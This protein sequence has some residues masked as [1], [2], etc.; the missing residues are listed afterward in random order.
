[1]D[2]SESGGRVVLL[3]DVLL[4]IAGP[5]RRGDLR[6]DLGSV[7]LDEVAVILLSRVDGCSFIS[8]CFG[9]CVET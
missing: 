1:M 5:C 6:S 8:L 2:M 4:V 9:T 3:E 7:E